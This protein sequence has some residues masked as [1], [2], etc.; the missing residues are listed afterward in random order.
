MKEYYKWMEAS[1]LQITDVIQ[2]EYRFTLEDDDTNLELRM[3]QILLLKVQEK[4]LI[5]VFLVRLKKMKRS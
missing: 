3:V 4:Q 5:Q 2:N 1:E